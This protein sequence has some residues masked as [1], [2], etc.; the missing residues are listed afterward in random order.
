M[1]NDFKGLKLLVCLEFFKKI[2]SSTDFFQNQ[3]FWKILSEIQSECQTYW[4]QIRPDRN[5]GPDL[6]QNCLQSY[7]QTTAADK[8]LSN[9]SITGKKCNPSSKDF[10]IA[11]A[12]KKDHVSYI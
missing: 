9:N 12:H 7:Q 10:S 2:L 11:N 1:W 4:L 3:L 5:V 8:E 6:G